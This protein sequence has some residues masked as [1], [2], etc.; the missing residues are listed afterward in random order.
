MPRS[1]VKAPTGTATK[2]VSGV[3]PYFC[4]AD[5]AVGSCA[6]VL[7]ME[8]DCEIATVVRR[9]FGRFEP[10]GMAK[11]RLE[12]EIPE[13]IIPV[14]PGCPFGLVVIGNGGVPDVS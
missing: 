6:R 8:D 5:K 12:V 10:V 7:P 11:P 1:E 3:V 4:Q 2:V 9:S 14:R 13:D